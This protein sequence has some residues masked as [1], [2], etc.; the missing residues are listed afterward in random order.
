MA[1]PALK[2]PALTRELVCVPVDV[3]GDGGAVVVP[4]GMALQLA[5][6]LAGVQP[7][8]P[9]TGS[10]PDWYAG[11]W[12]TRNTA[13]TFQNEEGVWETW[14]PPVYLARLL[15][16]SGGGAVVL[17]VGSTYDLW[18]DIAPGGTERIVEPSG[19]VRAV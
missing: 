2:V 16:G 19:L 5:V 18:V 8:D 10:Q 4:T 6:P 9:K 7:S 14:Q 15:V 11:S 12:E 13:Y 3:R 17:T 1:V